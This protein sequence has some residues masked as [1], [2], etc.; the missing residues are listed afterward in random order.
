MQ[1]CVHLKS[2]NIKGNVKI[3]LSPYIQLGM[4]KQD[5]RELKEINMKQ[6]RGVSAAQINQ[7]ISNNVN[8]LE[9]IKM[10]D[11][12]FNLSLL[13][14]ENMND[15]LPLKKLDLSWCEDCNTKTLINFIK[16]CP[17]LLSFKTRACEYVTNDVILALASNCHHLQQVNISRCNN[18]Q[19]NAIIALAKNN[20]KTL[21]S[22]DI[23]WSKCTNESITVILEFCKKLCILSM[24]GCK[25]SN[26]IEIET[27]ILQLDALKHIRMAWVNSC[28][29]KWAKKVVKAKP[30]L[31]IVEYYGEE[32]CGKLYDDGRRCSTQEE[33]VL[34]PD[35]MVNN[36]NMSDSP[37]LDR[38]PSLGRL[39][40]LGSVDDVGFDTDYNAYSD[41]DF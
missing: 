21:T 24:E 41:D 4:D 6:V 7:I 40:L 16:K 11:T 12:E 29:D 5:Q 9:I 17:N 10:G 3:E 37:K 26:V 39:S 8:S 14:Y 23:A 18:V 19:D 34:V 38:F 35:E 22:L 33:A 1:D 30:N 2:I 20:F 27:S 32:I 15:V 13:P 31:C 25:S 28:D 36:N